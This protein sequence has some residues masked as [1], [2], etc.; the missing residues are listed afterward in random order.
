MH[1][2]IYG[3]SCNPGSFLLHFMT[4]LL[5][6][7]ACWDYYSPRDAV[8][9][10]PLPQIY[11]K[12]TDWNLDMP[13]NAALEPVYNLCLDKCRKDASFLFWFY[14]L[15]FWYNSYFF[16]TVLLSIA[17]WTDVKHYECMLISDNNHADGGVHGA[18]WWVHYRPWEGEGNGL[19]AV[20]I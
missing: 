17:Y 19:G 2:L 7:C 12:M 13:C 9:F 5:C 18:G 11:Y 15:I 14:R 10:L 8:A 20:P 3:G 6:I 16:H 4:V 1:E